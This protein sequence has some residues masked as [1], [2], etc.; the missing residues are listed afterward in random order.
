MNELVNELSC[1]LNIFW[2]IFNQLWTMAFWKCIRNCKATERNGCFHI[3]VTVK[4]Q[5][6][7]NNSIFLLSPL[8]QVTKFKFKLNINL[9][10]YYLT[11]TKP[12]FVKVINEHPSSKGTPYCKRK[13]CKHQREYKEN[14]ISIWL[15]D[16][17]LETSKCQYLTWTILFKIQSGMKILLLQRCRGGRTYFTSSIEFFS[18]PAWINY[19][20]ESK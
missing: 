12:H 1:V 3:L 14:N 9:G 8:P 7:L 20:S 18:S 10:I 13:H 16:A 2:E 6:I 15:S 5:L 4:P 19:L 11:G 17:V